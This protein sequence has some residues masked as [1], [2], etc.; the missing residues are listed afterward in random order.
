VKLLICTK[1]GQIFNLEFHVKYCGCG[2]TF[3]KY[4]EDGDSVEISPKAVCLGVDNKQLISAIKNRTYK[5]EYVRNF[6]AWVFNDSFFKITRM[7]HV[8]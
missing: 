4:L 7:E 5:E 8:D 2:Q 6:N 1:C 3:G